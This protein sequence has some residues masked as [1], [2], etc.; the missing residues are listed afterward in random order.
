MKQVHKEI[1]E[2]VREFSGATL[3]QIVQLMPHVGPASLK[4]EIRSVY[5]MGY[6]DKGHTPNKSGQGKRLFTYSV[7][8]NPQPRNEP[9]IT[10]R[11]RLPTE[12]G[13][14]FQINALKEQIA[15]LENWKQDAIERFPDLAVP[16]TVFQARKWVA[17]E[18]RQCGDHAMACE[19]EAG[20]KDGIL[21]MRVA[22]RVLDSI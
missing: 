5:L 10:R 7:N 22:I 15:E 14:T 8:D 6:L 13:Y 4:K 20:R 16:P 21:P 18:M 3:E 2:V 19:V 12:S 11:K 1:L 9:I 17:A